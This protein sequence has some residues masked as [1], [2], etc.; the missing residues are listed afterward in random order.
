VNSADGKVRYEDFFIKE[1]MPFIE[2]KYR[3]LAQRATRGLLGISMGG[4]GAMHYAFKYPQLFGSVSTHMAAL[5]E[6]RPPE[7]GGTA[8]GSLSAAIFGEPFNEPYYK[9]QSPFTLASKAPVAELKRS[10]IYFD[11]GSDDSYGFAVGTEALDKLLTRRGIPHQ[12][13]L[14]PGTHNVQF[15]AEHLPASLMF[16]SKAFG[17]GPKQAKP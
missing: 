10:A 6:S 1:F 16:E 13:H 7:M 15:V 2:H 12:A 3:V 4:Y 5:R 11:C 14:Y 9:A 8:Q 17:L